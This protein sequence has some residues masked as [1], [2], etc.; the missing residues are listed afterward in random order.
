[1]SFVSS[2]SLAVEAPFVQELVVLPMH[3]LLPDLGGGQQPE[4]WDRFK[5]VQS[6]SNYTKNIKIVKFLN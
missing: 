3:Q 1:L 6:Q 5:V 4:M 2:A